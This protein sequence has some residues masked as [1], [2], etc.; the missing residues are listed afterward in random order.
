MFGT[1]SGCD[2]HFSGDNMIIQK[3]RFLQIVVSYRL[4]FTRLLFTG[5]LCGL[6]CRVVRFSTGSFGLNGTG[7]VCSELTVAA[8]VGDNMIIQKERFLQIVVSY[9]LVFTRLLLTGTLCGLVCRVVRFSTGSVG[10]NGSRECM[11]GTNSGCDCHFSGDNLII[12]KERF[13]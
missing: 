7:S 9:R 10:L 3:E 11:F 13:L 2:C 4:V 12:Q 6:V 5:T 8:T 1:N